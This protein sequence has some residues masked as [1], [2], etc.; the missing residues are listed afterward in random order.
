MTMSIHSNAFE[1]FR[2]HKTPVRHPGKR[3]SLVDQ[4]PSSFDCQARIARISLPD[5]VMYSP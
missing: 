1:N 5:R 3:S 4:N 2:Y